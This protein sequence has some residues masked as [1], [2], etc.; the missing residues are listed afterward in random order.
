MGLLKFYLISLAIKDVAF[1]LDN[2]HVP[3]NWIHDHWV[4]ISLAWGATNTQY[5]SWPCHSADPESRGIYRHTN[6]G[7]CDDSI[8]RR[9]LFLSAAA[10]A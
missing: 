9:N 8:E 3:L 10:T 4:Q 2:G 5:L 7:E 6:R 1:A